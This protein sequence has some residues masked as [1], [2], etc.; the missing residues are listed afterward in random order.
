M[1]GTPSKKAALLDG[2][3]FSSTLAISLS[4]ITAP[5]V[6]VTIGKFNSAFFDSASVSNLML[7][8][9]LSPSSVPAGRLMLCCLSALAIEDVVKPYSFKTRGSA[10]IDQVLS[11]TPERITFATV[12]SE[13]NWSCRFFE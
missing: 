13:A 11:P 8:S 1:T 12:S 9:P 3:Y 10:S 4:L 6:N 5:L 7:Y 2:S